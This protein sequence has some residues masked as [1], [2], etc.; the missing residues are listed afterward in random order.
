VPDVPRQLVPLPVRPHLLEGEALDSY[1]ERTAAASHRTNPELLTRLDGSTTRFLSIAPSAET[2]TKLA[3]LTGQ[4]ES[5]LRHGTLA[6]LALPNTE[7]SG[8]GWRR[9]GRAWA[10]GR[11][12]QI[13]PRCLEPPD[14]VW[15]ITWRHP[16]VTVCLV[17]R[18]W[19][20]ATCPTCGVAFRMQR[21]SP[22]RSVDAADGTCGNPGGTRGRTCPQDLSALASVP[23]PAEVLACQERIDTA[24]HHQ[25]VTVLGSLMAGEAYLEEVRVLAVLLLH[26]AREDRDGALA[27][28]ADAARLDHSRSAARRGARWGLTPPADPVLR[29]QALAAADQILATADTDGAAERIGPWLDLT[30]PVPVGQLGWLADHTKMT[31]LLTRLVMAATSTRRRLSTLL[32]QEDPIDTRWIP[33][34]VPADLYGAHLAGLIDVAE[35]TGR[36]FV[37]LCLARAGR[38][39][40]TW[41]DAA[42]A[43]G[44]P[45]EVGTKTARACSGDIVCSAPALIEAITAAGRDLNE[46]ADYRERETVVRHLAARSRW[47]TSWARTH[48]PGTRA[49]SK[50]YA[51]AWLWTAYAGGHL[52][53]SPGWTTTPSTAERA[54]SRRYA[55]RLNETAL[56]ALIAMAAATV[57]RRR[58]TTEGGAACVAAPN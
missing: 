12:T 4:D 41:A 10:P 43:L 6:T 53:T 5:A 36:L 39:G 58:S 31:P 51:I 29:G 14:G 2:L 18:T 37:A 40:M 45:G 57:P 48:G 47:Y 16:W 25:P 33:Q 55:A 44:L 42:T 3:V 34:V 21:S 38:P 1:L 24:I 7:D 49:T 28:W 52:G 27:P 50:R 26:L 11:G 30:Q 9:A 46:D 20:N 23:A 13:C 32:V 22:L 35:A 17:H 15:H 19:L 56:Q 8:N 54:R